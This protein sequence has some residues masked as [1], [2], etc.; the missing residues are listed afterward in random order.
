MKKVNRHNMKA[1]QKKALKDVKHKQ[2]A[3][4]PKKMM[5]K[6]LSTEEG[7]ILYLNVSL[8]R[9]VQPKKKKKQKSKNF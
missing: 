8:E 1:I 7:L 3:V 2:N 4:L 6:P 9:I 5:A